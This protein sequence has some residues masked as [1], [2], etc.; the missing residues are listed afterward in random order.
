MTNSDVVFNQNDGIGVVNIGQIITVHLPGEKMRA[1]V[2]GIHE[3]GGVAV[4]L[5]G[6]PMTKE[7]NH[8]TG[9][10][11]DCRMVRGAIGDGRWELIR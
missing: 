5:T 6:F 8:R 10:V 4:K 11:V 9:D 2:V 7:H 3:E 1:E